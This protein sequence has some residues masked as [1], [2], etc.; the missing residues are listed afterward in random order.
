[1]RKAAGK[2]G[3]AATSRCADRGRKEETVHTGLSGS[4]HKADEKFKQK[5]EPGKADQS[6]R[7]R[8]H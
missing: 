2:A 8:R 6:K 3:S 1:M 7:Q 4:S 5:T